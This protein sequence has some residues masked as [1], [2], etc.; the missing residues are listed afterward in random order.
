MPFTFLSSAARAAPKKG[1]AAFQQAARPFNICEKIFSPPV[2]P[3]LRLLHFRK[4]GRSGRLAHTA[5]FLVRRFRAE[6]HFRIFLVHHAAGR[7]QNNV[8]AAPAHHTAHHLHVADVIE[9]VSYTH[10][11]VYK[12]QVHIR[13]VMGSSPLFSTTTNKSEPYAGRR[14]VRI[15]YF[16]G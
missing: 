6:R 4:A 10:L 14:W 8:A 3:R 13:E 2:G 12:R 11:D 15:C 16:T 1:R 5:R 9:P 7:I